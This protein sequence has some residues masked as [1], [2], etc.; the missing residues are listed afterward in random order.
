MRQQRLHQRVG[1]RGALASI[2]ACG[3]SPAK[4]SAASLTLPIGAGKVALTR[5]T[6]RFK[7]RICINYIPSRSSPKNS[8]TL[9]LE[10]RVNKGFA[11][12]S[13]GYPFF[14]HVS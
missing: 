10:T 14:P 7:E 5:L 9:G 1:R 11:A 6:I 4:T 3:C 13:T 2:S 12:K 8:G